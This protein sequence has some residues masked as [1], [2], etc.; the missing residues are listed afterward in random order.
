M[1]SL[2]SLV[3]TLRPTKPA[4]VPAHLGPACQAWFL[5]LVRAADPA[6]AERLHGASRRRPYTVPSLRDTGSARRGQVTLDPGQ[7]VWVRFTSLEKRLSAV[8]LEEVAPRLPATVLLGDAELAVET[9]TADAEAHPWAGQ[10][11]YE[12]LLQHHLL[13]SATPGRAMGLHFASPTTFRRTG[14]TFEGMRVPDHDLPLPLPD[15]VFGSLADAWEAFAPVK[16]ARDVRAFAAVGLSIRRFRLHTRWVNDG[17]SRRW[18]MLGT[19][20]YQ[21]LTDDPLWLR[22]LHLLAAFS[23][24]CG[25]GRGTTAGWGQTRTG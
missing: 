14:G 13:S 5:D 21:A 18:G 10:S 1:S 15:L 6:L 7:S 19:C 11:S 12:T 22:L 23:F 4:T 3:V 25:T 16:L 24:F 8:L 2:V 9:A 20:E 17:R